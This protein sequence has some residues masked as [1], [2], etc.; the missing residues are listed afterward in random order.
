[1]SRFGEAA[2]ERQHVAALASQARAYLAR[3]EAAMRRLADGS[4]GICLCPADSRSTPGYPASEHHLPVLRHSPPETATSHTRR[5]L[6]EC[7]RR[8]RMRCGAV[9]RS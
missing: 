7:P 6:S 4:Y 2:F 8:R 5:G 9:R 1:M 3:I